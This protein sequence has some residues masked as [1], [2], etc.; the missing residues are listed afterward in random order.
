MVQTVPWNV[1]PL[2]IEPKAVVLT[3]TLWIQ[4]TSHIHFNLALIQLIAFKK[5]LRVDRY[6]ILQVQWMTSV[7][8][9]DWGLGLHKNIED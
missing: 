9:S 1:V 3:T 2:G 4:T 8:Y 6:L 7:K 5:L